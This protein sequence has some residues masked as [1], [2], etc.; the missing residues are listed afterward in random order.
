MGLKSLD[1]TN[2]NHQFFFTSLAIYSKEE[3]EL[4]ADGFEVKEAWHIFLVLDSG[5]HSIRK[6]VSK[7]DCIEH[8]I[9]RLGTIHSGIPSAVFAHIYV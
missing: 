6:H 7:Q 3:T 5:H 9:L 8:I 4:N 2:R 1:D